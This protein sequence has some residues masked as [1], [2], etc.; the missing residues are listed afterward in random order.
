MNAAN[1]IT[2]ANDQTL[3][4]FVRSAKVRLVI[5]APAV[6]TSVGEAIA[7]RWSALGRDAVTVVLDVD[8]EVYRLGYGN[9]EA[10]ER[11]EQVAAAFGTMVTRHKGIRVGM[12]IADD[13]T[14][15]YSPTPQLIEAGPR[16]PDAPNAIMLGLP[17]PQVERELGVGPEGV[18]DQRIGE[19]KATKAEIKAVSE[20][21]KTNPPQ[22]FDVAR[23]MRVFNSLIEFVEFELTGTMLERHKAS[24][25][26]E[27]MGLANDKTTRDLIDAQFRLIDR[28]SKISGVKLQESKQAV[29]DEFLTTLPR[30]GQVILRAKK[31][32]FET[33]IEAFQE[34]VAAFAEQV[35]KDL[36]AEMK[37]NRERIVEV[38][39][40]TVRRAVPSQ[41]KK[42]VVGEMSDEKLRTLLDLALAR[43]FGG[44]EKHIRAMKVRVVFKGVTFESLTDPEFVKV[45]RDRLPALDQIHREFTAV[46]G[47][48]GS[49]RD[50]RLGR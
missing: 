43:E 5:L 30:Y 41:W 10:L 2:V 21:L 15:V 17:P 26:A 28:D 27:L 18:K 6:S 48:S 13:R 39:L 25:P 14:L 24:L 22:K 19:D 35:R 11:L 46:Q 31:K 36:D 38:L 23:T 16:R 33:R 47:S 44:A 49:A 32:E 40:P 37:A 1:A 34:E 42:Q 45:A 20:D 12:V 9:I 7:D 29:M 50:E 8:P 4:E 3:S